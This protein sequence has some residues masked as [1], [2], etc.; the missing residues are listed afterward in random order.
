MVLVL[1]WKN[2]IPKIYF[3]F[4]VLFAGN[5]CVDLALAWLVWKCHHREWKFGIV[6]STILYDLLFWHALSTN[7]DTLMPWKW[8]LLK[9]CW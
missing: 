1:N 9:V 6:A 4:E 8:F 3:I 7:A 2:H 5:C